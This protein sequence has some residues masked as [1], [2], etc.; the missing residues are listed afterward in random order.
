M[1]PE[2]PIVLVPL[3][4]ATI[5]LLPPLIRVLRKAFG[6][7]VS[8]GPAVVPPPAAWR[9]ERGQCAAHV[10]VDALALAKRQEWDRMLGVTDL[11]LFAPELN[12]VFGEADSRRGVAVMSI[13]RFATKRSAEDRI[14]LAATEAV[15]ELGHT[16]GLRHCDDAHCVMWF[17]NTLAE[18]ERKG[19][20]FCARHAAEMATRAPWRT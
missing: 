1:P 20:R 5:E 8:L 17:S 3:A 16:Y 9:K 7:P 19:H 10:L 11:D 18:T 12:F 13:Y 4:D 14:R 6:R 2:A 15:H